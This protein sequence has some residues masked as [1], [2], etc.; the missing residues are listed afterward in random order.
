MEKNK[1]FS[2]FCKP[3][4][5]VDI[6]VASINTTNII[7]DVEDDASVDDAMP[8]KAVHEPTQNVQSDINVI[9]DLGDIDSGPATPILDVSFIT[10]TIYI[11]IYNIMYSLPKIS[12][13][14]YWLLLFAYFNIYY[15]GVS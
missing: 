9:L 15:L 12:P 10:Y 3:K 2:I 7:V 8:V 6:S 1:L 5:S 11:I 13:K 4:Q 14:T